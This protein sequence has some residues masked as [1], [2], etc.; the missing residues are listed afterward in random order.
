[1]EEK[2]QIF[3]QK[4]LDRVSSPEQLDKYI[5]T[6]TPTVWLLMAAI[7][8]FLCGTI[9]W[10]TV[11]KIETSSET[12]CIVDGGTTTCIISEFN[13]ERLSADT[14][15][16]I[17][18]KQY[19]VKAG[20]SP[21]EANENTNAFILHASDI[22]EGDWYYE[23]TAKTNLANGEYKAKVVYEIISPIKFVLN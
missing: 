6:T 8:V 11:G 10:A 4:S 17:E 13:Y 2:N 18:E 19:E 12:G 16:E 20:K 15:L 23:I 22:N 5:K 14:Y 7:I 1:M 21:L 3:R 9:V